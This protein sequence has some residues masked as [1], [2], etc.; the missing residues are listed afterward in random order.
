MTVIKE[1][2]DALE[3]LPWWKRM[4]G[5]P[6]R[7]DDLERRLKLV[8]EKY[9]GKWPPDVC[10]FCGDRACRLTASL[11]PMKIGKMQEN[12]RCGSCGQIEVRV[13]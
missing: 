6:D 5:V 10:K 13:V 12:W 4:S 2:Q 1:I 11:G 3:K 9:S 8:E 7:V